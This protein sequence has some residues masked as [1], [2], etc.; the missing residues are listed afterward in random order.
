MSSAIH[1]VTPVAPRDLGKL[2]ACVHS[3][4]FAADQLGLGVEH[5]V[6]V[7]GPPKSEGLTRDFVR[8]IGVGSWSPSYQLRVFWLAVPSGPANARNVAI[9][10]FD[11]SDLVFFIDADDLMTPN[12]LALRVKAMEGLDKV[13]CYGAVLAEY[14]GCSQVPQR[15]P[16][17]AADRLK[18]A[19]Q[20]CNPLI[21][22]MVG[23]RA[24]LIQDVGGFEPYLVCGE[25]GNLFRRMLN[26]NPSIVRVDE[27]VAA[28]RHRYRSQSRLA[29]LDPHGAALFHPKAFHLDKNK[30]GPM[31]QALDA[32]AEI[33]G[34]TFVAARRSGFDAFS[35]LAP[36][37]ELDGTELFGG[38]HG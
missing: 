11:P 26:R 32:D 16:L 27:A 8:T 34:A 20:A 6:V 3:V 1:V 21:P 2:D 33:R 9:A 35:V 7:D 15:S 4:R 23:T 30:Y 37:A 38:C 24:G 12:S 36:G 13:F 5:A 31:G 19:L 14:E 10:S 25:D 28:Y 18:T 17:I 22:D 29:S